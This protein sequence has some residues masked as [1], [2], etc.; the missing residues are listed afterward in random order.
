MRVERN[1][2]NELYDTTLVTIIAV[3][4]SML[5][6]KAIGEQLGTPTTVKGTLKL[7]AA[8][9]AGML[10]VKYMQSKTWLPT[11]PFKSQ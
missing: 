11:D 4:V 3:A 8:V 2:M 6:K 7:S 1:V 9:G 10:G 5:S